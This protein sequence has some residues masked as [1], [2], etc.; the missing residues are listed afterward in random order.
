MV[1]WSDLKR[2][3]KFKISFTKGL[4]IFLGILLSFTIKQNS[5]AVSNFNVSS[6]DTIAGYSTLI[7]TSQ[8]E[9]NTEVDF[10]VTK[11]NEAEIK[12]TAKTNSAGIAEAE[13]FGYNTKKTGLYTIS[14]KRK[15]EQSYNNQ[16]SFRVYPD[17]LSSSQSTL[18]SST[19]TVAGDNTEKA[20]LT[21]TLTDK[22]RN[23]ISNHQVKLISSRPE[24]EIKLSS[25]SI[26]DENGNVVFELSSR[27]PGISVYSAFDVN[28]GITLDDRVKVVYFTPYESNLPRGGNY[29]Q[30]D[31]FASDDSEAKIDETPSGP[32]KYFDITIPDEVPINTAQTIKVTARDNNKNIARDYTGTVLFATPDDENATLPSEDGEFTF[33]DKDLGEFTFNLAI[34]FTKLGVQTIQ[35]F[36]EE[37]WDILGEKKI[38]VVEQNGNSQTPAP[39]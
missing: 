33:S 3:M 35:V 7:K 38:N 24:D 14:A 29:L 11:P 39:I 22:Y 12:L 2:K 10:L 26:S 37:D 31:L 28:T 23:P 1:K 36:D 25:K 34:T 27:Y 16:S 30:A 9:P 15:T 32:V 8:I 17:T 19:T 20:Y 5:L 13:L 6:T 18:K 21:V 4:Q